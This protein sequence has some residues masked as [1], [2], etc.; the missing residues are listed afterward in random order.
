M[1]HTHHFV[2]KAEDKAKY[3]Y[4]AKGER[5]RIEDYNHSS[6]R[7]LKQF[8]KPTNRDKSIL[9]TF[10]LKVPTVA[11]FTVS[12]DTPFQAFTFYTSTFCSLDLLLGRLPKVDLLGRL[13]K[14]DLII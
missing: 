7:I 5:G 12:S 13:P 10:R 14:V 4:N 1:T 2:N 6:V 9:N 11:R 8:L 3:R